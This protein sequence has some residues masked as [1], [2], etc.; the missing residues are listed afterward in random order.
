MDRESI[1]EVVRQSLDEVFANLRG[2]RAGAEGWTREIKTQ[3]C[4]AGAP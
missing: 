3:L 4:L 2:K 1:S